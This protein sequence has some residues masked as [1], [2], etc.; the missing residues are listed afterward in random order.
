MGKI[1]VKTLG[2]ESLEQK[3][4]EKSKQKGKEKKLVKGA[5]GGER[6]VSVGASEEE[7]SKIAVPQNIEAKPGPAKEEKKEKEVKIKQGKKKSRSKSY[8]TVQQLIEKDKKYALEKALDILPKLSRS[9][10]DETVELHINTVTTG[11]S[12]NITLPHGT[13]KSVRVAIADPT[14]SSGQ[15]KVEELIKKIGS[16]NIDFDVLIAT[17]EA[18]PK[19]AKVAKILGPRGLM[20]NPKSGTIS[21]TP[22]KLAQ[23]FEKGQINF[24]TETKAP[25]MHLTVGKVSF[26]EKKLKEN[27]DALIQAIKKENI[28]NVTLK[29][30]M[31]P[32]IKISL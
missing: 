14:T 9:K 8:Q 13:G 24:K 10:F 12:G 21:N 16:G 17:P 27:I 6:V 1:R 19:L 29:S 18:M 4:K 28:R 31:S 32:G 2:D 7:I 15:A 26:G 22:E 25:I 20:P 11:I 30:T 5:K 3:Q 23:N